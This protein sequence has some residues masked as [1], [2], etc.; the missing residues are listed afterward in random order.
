[1][2]L[3]SCGTDRTSNRHSDLS[4]AP[5]MTEPHI[6]MKRQSRSVVLWKLKVLNN[7]MST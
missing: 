3:E 4:K 6:T 7:I 5:A 1:M 2:V